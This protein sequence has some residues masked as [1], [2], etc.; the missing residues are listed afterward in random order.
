MLV[1]E[2]CIIP[3]YIITCCPKKD[4]SLFFFYCITTFQFFC[5]SFCIAWI[6]FHCS[7]FVFMPYCKMIFLYL[8]VA[9]FSLKMISL[10]LGFMLPQP[11]ESTSDGTPDAAL[12]G[13]SRGGGSDALW[14]WRF[15]ICCRIKAELSCYEM[16]TD[17]Q[18]LP[19][20][21]PSGFLGNYYMKL[22]F[23]LNFQTIC[24]AMSCQ[25][26]TVCFDLRCTRNCTELY[27]L[28]F[29]WC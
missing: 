26:P 19:V 6:V 20:N 4:S 24:F 2:I 18:Q 3:A 17:L 1:W 5:S 12:A 13:R 23:P 14:W 9:L 7:P 8:Q 11:C 25:G 10:Y 21:E 27:L 16:K 22:F 29:P 15:L 28:F